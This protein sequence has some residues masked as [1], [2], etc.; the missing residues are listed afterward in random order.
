MGVDGRQAGNRHQHWDVMPLDLGV[1][2]LGAEYSL[3]FRVSCLP[4]RQVIV[5]EETALGTKDFL[6]RRLTAIKNQRSTGELEDLALI[7]G[8]SLV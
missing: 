7:I 4:H 6:E 1:Y 3:W 2:E 8:Q 5:N